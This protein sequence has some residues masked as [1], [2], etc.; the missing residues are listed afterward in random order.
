MDRWLIFFCIVLIT[1]ITFNSCDSS[2]L[3][4]RHDVQSLQSVGPDTDERIAQYR[5][6]IK[7]NKSEFQ[8]AIQAAGRIARFNKLLAIQYM[9]VGMFGL[10]LE[11]LQEALLIEPQNEVLF[12]L[13]GVSSMQVAKVYPVANAEYTRLIN[14][15]EYAFQRSA[16]LNKEYTDPLLALSM[17]YIFNKEEPNLALPLLE[18]LRGLE[19]SNPHVHALI[20]R[21]HV[22]DGDF[23]Q[24][25]QSYQL[26]AELYNETEYRQQSLDNIATIE[27]LQRGSR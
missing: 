23:A 19:P 26:A 16:E 2:L 9:E 12:Y 22:A 10:A 21:V 4:K 13:S 25:T 1:S 27:S 20:G 24:A 14:D 6:A 5:D 3:R 11:S 8:Q 15:A 18:R 7:K 17:L